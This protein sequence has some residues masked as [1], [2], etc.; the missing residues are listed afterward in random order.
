MDLK[1]AKI[2]GFFSMPSPHLAAHNPSAY[3]NAITG[4]P[5]GAGSCYHCGTAIL[6][7]VVVREA[8][9][10]VRLIGTTCAE[11]VGLNVKQVR[12]RITD[13]QLA[14]QNAR[15][16]AAEDERQRKRREAEE[17]LA[18]QIATRREHVGFLVDMLREKGGYF[19]ES[20]ADQLE[21]RPLSERQALYVAKATSD[22]GRRN[23]KN[24]EAFDA[25]I[26]L[27]VDD[28]AEEA[29]GETA[30]QSA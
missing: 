6:H 18:L 30:G 15:R 14:A 2:I 3:S 25:V 21:V 16:A 27:C 13:E 26:G 23:K 12:Y 19:Y 7:H 29:A 10:E 5:A 20:L 8:T 4:L 9:G 22:T 17:A 1:N 24:A 28:F 11:R